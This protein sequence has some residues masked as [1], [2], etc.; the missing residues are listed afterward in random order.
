MSG[1]DVFVF[2][3]DD[4]IPTTGKKG[5]TEAIEESFCKIALSLSYLSL[6]HISL[7]KGWKELC[8]SILAMSGGDA[9]F[10]LSLFD[11]VHIILGGQ[12]NDPEELFLQSAGEGG[13]GCR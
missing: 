6:S 3:P 1:T 7:S 9:C 13:H 12:W 4:Q 11:Q 10:G 2:L 5:S 8:V